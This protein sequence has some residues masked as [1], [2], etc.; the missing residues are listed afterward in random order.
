MVCEFLP[1]EYKEKLVDIATLEDLLEAGYSPTSV[2]KMKQKKAISDEKCEKLV[3]ILGDRARPVILDAF[4]AFAKELGI[5]VNISTIDVSQLSRM[6]EDK[7][8][9]IFEEYCGK[10][11]STDKK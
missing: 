9:T 11:K 4:Q 6:I 1:R 2:Y 10:L 3:E 7:I 8:R 5:S